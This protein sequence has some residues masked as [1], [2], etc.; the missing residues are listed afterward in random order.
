MKT[1]SL[2]VVVLL[3]F[4]V[5]G[6]AAEPWTLERAI[7]Q[8]LTNSPDARLAQ[9]R[10][11][12]AQAGLQQ[13][14]AAF[15]PQ[16]QF[17][18][19]YLQTDNPM[20]VFGAALNQR[21]FSFGMDFNNVPNADNLNLNGT[22][23][24]ALYNGGQNRAGRKAALAG[25]EAARQMAEA[26]RNTLAFE[27]ARAFNTVLKT[28]EFIQATEAGVTAF[29]ANLAVATKRYHAGTALKNE[30]LDLE[31]RLAQAKED[32]ARALNANALSLRALRTVLGLEETEFEI[33]ETAP[34]VPLP[35]ATNL[36]LRPEL[37]AAAAQIRA[38]EAEV[39]RA[40]GGFL[41]RVNAFGRYDYDE[42]W[43]FDGSGDSYAA[44]VQLQWNVWDGELTRGRVRQA[45]A[46]LEAA[47]EEER[48]LRLGLG[49][50][51]EQAQLNLKEARERLAVTEKA[52]AQA[53]ESAQLTRARFEQ[54]LALSTQ[55]IDAETALTGARVRRAEAEADR[56][57]AVAAL[58]KALG[59]PQLPSETTQP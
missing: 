8:A 51:L 2:A 24:L 57:I 41:P 9:S 19:S 26:V 37:A 28:R 54:G 21:A 33:A 39:R 4:A 47:R 31:V 25:S 40:Q 42:G 6:R 30:V 48:K 15:M 12:A 10:I 20:M 14:N 13:A 35:L 1:R 18:A 22:L 36:T 7:A 55:T 49:L 23:Y 44:G 27:V 46:G 58:R 50:E 59:L 32:R 17:N 16:L 45:R 5:A 11:A 53:T 52:V 38:A 56:R 34:I 29:E 3:G 43:K